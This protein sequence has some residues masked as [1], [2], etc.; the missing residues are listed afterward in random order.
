MSIYTRK[1]TTHLDQINAIDAAYKRA[2]I[3]SPNRTLQIEELLNMTPTTLQVT[4]RLAREALEVTDAAK[5]YKSALAE[6]RDAQAA[7][8]FRDRFKER[9]GAHTQ[10][11]MTSILDHATEDLTAAFQELAANFAKAA[12]RLPRSNPL[13]AEANLTAETGNDLKVA[14]DALSKLG[15]YASMFLPDVSGTAGRDAS[16]ILGIVHIPDCVTEKLERFTK[17]ALNTDELGNT[18]AVREFLD[19]VGKDADIALT[20]LARGDWPT[21]TLELADTTEHRRRFDAV[22]T[23]RHTQTV[24]NGKLVL[25]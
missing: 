11:N 22:R 8:A 14:R 25:R 7:D 10:L 15:A 3:P 13:D 1:P 18:Y 6:I 23:A 2:G 20:R 19:A 4:D 16:Q 9:V 17:V 21:L 12:K 24:E 5:F